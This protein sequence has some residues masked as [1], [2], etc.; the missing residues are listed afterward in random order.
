[1][2]VWNPSIWSL[3]V[4]VPAFLITAFRTTT[5]FPDDCASPASWGVETYG[6]IWNGPHV[7]GSVTVPDVAAEDDPTGPQVAIKAPLALNALSV[8]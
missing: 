7:D 6:E 1:M 4:A 5:W 2:N 8:T 3:A